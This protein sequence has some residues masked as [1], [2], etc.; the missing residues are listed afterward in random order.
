LKRQ[1]NE[2]LNWEISSCSIKSSA[3]PNFDNGRIKISGQ[4]EGIFR[5]KLLSEKNTIEIKDGKFEIII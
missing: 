2:H 5:S 4:L 3:I 1:K